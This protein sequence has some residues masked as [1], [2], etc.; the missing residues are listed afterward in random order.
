MK[1]LLIIDG[2]HPRDGGPPAVVAGSATALR[3]HGRDVTVLTTL[4]PNDEDDVRL[5]WGGMVN[6]GVA[7]RFCAPVTL[8]HLLGLAA[9]DPTMQEAVAAADVV[10]IHGFWTPALLAAAKM[11][12]RAGKPYFL[13]THGLLDRRAM[14]SVR[15]KWIKKRL[16]I[17]LLGFRPV[18]RD[19]SG[20][21]FGSETEGNE[22]WNP[23]AGM[24]KHYIPNGVEASVGRK[25][26]TANARD[27]LHAVAPQFDNCNRWLLFY[28]RIHPE[29]GLD[30]L[31]R[32]FNAVC[33]DFP[34]Y[35]LLIA[36]IMKDKEYGAYV[37]ELV[38]QCPAP[39]RIVFTTSLTGPESHFLYSLCDIFVLPSHAEGFSVALTE[40][41]AH[42]LP[43][44]ITR[45]CHLPLVER[46]G[47]GVVVDPTNE[48]IEAGLRVLL[49]LSDDA[50]AEM[51]ANARAL[52][53]KRFTWDRVAEQ[54]CVAYAAAVAE[55]P[56]DR[57]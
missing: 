10:H 35:G 15:T 22:S 54:L 34:N 14:T 40:A 5:T 56:H 21:I 26:V 13:S 32:A 52:F 37:K 2:M 33:L 29:K 43:S 45:Y 36:G 24:R 6:D 51:G 44:L 8:K 23:V 53:D 20:V 18:F 7:L 12:R 1:I 11:A 3:R 42:A 27:R 38:R 31:V 48:S 41:L 4:L 9:V 39:D 17:S 30:M 50:L 57:R 16:A 19:A 46:E 55:T 49:S 25:Q 47:A 28:S